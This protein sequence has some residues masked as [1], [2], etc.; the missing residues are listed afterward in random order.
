MPGV[1]VAMIKVVPSGSIIGSQRWSTG[2]WFQV[3]TTGTPAPADL[4]ASLALIAPIFDTWATAMK[5]FWLAPTTYDRVSAYYYAPGAV[6]S[7]LSAISSRTVQTGT[8]TSPQPPRTCVVASLQTGFPGKSFNGRSYTPWTGQTL[9]AA[10]Q[11]GGSVPGI[12]GAAYKAMANSM[13]ALTLGGPWGTAVLN[14]RSIA[15]GVAHPVT[16]IRVDTLPDTQRR[17]EDKIAA[18][19]S[20]VTVL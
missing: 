10:L 18:A 19:A 3:A 6:K 15:T 13:N 16:Q 8:G 7:T 4:V 5:V 1:S 20:V 17:H 12:I 2:L 14:V 9:T 11:F